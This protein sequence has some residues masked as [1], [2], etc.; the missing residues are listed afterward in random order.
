MKLSTDLVEQTLSQY[1]AR[2]IPENHPVVPELNE[3]FGD[4][5]FFVDGEGLSILEPVDPPQQGAEACKV[6]KLAEWSEGGNA[7]APHEPE[8]TEVVVV[9]DTAH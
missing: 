4:H 2:V 6:V 8:E 3:M 7:L 5:T 1:N 9:L